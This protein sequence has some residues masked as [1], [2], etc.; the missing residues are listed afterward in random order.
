MNIVGLD[1][2]LTATGIATDAG[3]F[4]VTTK[5]TDP[6]GKRLTNLRTEA[7]EHIK[8]AH[9]LVIE[10]L[11]VGQINNT[12]KLAKVHAAFEMLAW[13]WSTP[14][15]FIPPATLK[16]FATGK[17]TGD[18]R[19]MSVEAFKRFGVEGKDDN[20]IDAFWLRF[21]GQIHYGDTLEDWPKDRVAALHAVNPKTKQYRIEWPAIGGA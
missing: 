5:S 12:I 1:L 17:G 16:K 13:V 10:G 4:T 11:Y 9:L 6:M 18:K 21:A 20:Q 15:A 8:H 2:S 3:L 7:S 14:I 19:D